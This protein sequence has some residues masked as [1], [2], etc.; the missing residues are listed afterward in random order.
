M[1]EEQKKKVYEEKV[2]DF[3][4]NFGGGDREF[5]NSLTLITGVIP[6]LF[7]LLFFANGDPDTGWIGGLLIFVGIYG[8]WWSIK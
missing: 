8:W 3:I 6:L 2:N 7:A 1:N 5:F 4:N